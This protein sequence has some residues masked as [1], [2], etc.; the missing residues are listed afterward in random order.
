MGEDDQ[1]CDIVSWLFPSLYQISLKKAE[2]TS[3]LY[4]QVLCEGLQTHFLENL[5]LWILILGNIWN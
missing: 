4:F 2:L 1:A 5:D 3:A